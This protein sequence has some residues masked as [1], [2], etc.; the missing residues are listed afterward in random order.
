M[1]L[2]QASIAVRKAAALEGITDN[3]AEFTPFFDHANAGT[4]DEVKAK[5]NGVA[6]TTGMMAYADAHT[7]KEIKQ[8]S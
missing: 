6:I 4:P 2:L 5:V 3:D 1:K 7:W 8:R